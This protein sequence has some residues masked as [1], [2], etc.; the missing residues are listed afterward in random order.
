MGVLS[1][2]TFDLEFLLA[3]SG[4]FIPVNLGHVDRPIGQSNAS[5]AL[6]LP[7]S[8][9]SVELSQPC[10]LANR[11]T[12]GECLDLRDVAQNLEVHRL[13]LSGSPMSVN[14]AVNI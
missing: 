6:S 9:L 8:P 10:D 13:I 11:G 4:R 12:Y 1:Q 5:N 14:G 2:E 7:P 3:N